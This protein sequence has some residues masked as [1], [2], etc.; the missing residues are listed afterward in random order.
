M[1][2][3]RSPSELGRLVDRHDVELRE[4]RRDYITKELVLTM[5]GGLTDRVLRLEQDKASRRNLLLGI[6]GTLVG[7][8]AS[9]IITWL[10]TKGGGR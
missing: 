9:S 7:V 3:E 6:A 5:L 4:F 2:D 10:I 8:A 1:G